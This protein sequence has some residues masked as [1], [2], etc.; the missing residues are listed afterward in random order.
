MYVQSFLSKDKVLP[1]QIETN[2]S[3]PFTVIEDE[4][5]EL[6]FFF[7][8]DSL[9]TTSGILR[10]LVSNNKISH[11]D[12]ESWTIQASLEYAK[13]A[14]LKGQTEF[15]LDPQYSLGNISISVSGKLPGRT[16][17]ILCAMPSNDSALF[18]KGSED[19]CVSDK[20]YYKLFVE[21]RQRPID[22]VFN[23][24]LVLLVVLTNI[25]MGAKIDLN[26]MKTELKRPIAP[27]IGLCCQFLIMPMVAFG[28]ANSFK[29]DPGITL[30]FFA[31]GCAPGGSASNAYTYLLGGNVSLSVTMTLIST[32]AALGLLPMWLFTLGRVVYDT[33]DVRIPFENIFLSL[34]GIIIPAVIGL[35]L[36]RKFPKVAKFCVDAV[37]YIVIT[38][39]VFIMTVG[40]YANVYVF[41]LLSGE[42]LLAAALLPY[43]G[44]LL[45]GLVAFIFRLGKVNI[46]TIAVETGIQNTGIPIVLLRL[47]LMGPDKDTSIVAPVASA[48]FTPLPLVI[49][50]IYVQTKLYLEKRRKE[51]EG[52]AEK[53]LT[54]RREEPDVMMSPTDN[55]RLVADGESSQ[56]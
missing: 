10:N 44:F 1:F 23:I 47:S 42:V 9:N 49:G 25:G 29:L 39:V 13:I 6:V 21:R 24:V 14:E 34:L 38:M 11:T 52:T 40:I 45:G 28:I 16:Q 2:V 55:I 19:P 33:A 32:F 31:L 5:S 27:A 54:N 37:K 56:L 8:F 48:M 35:F 46:I 36:Q 30:G 7:K 3:F 4:I 50:V 53:S 41:F 43:L 12:N 18:K 17:L 26:V 22:V 51:R 20:M 15:L